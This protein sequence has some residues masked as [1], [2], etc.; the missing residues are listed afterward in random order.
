[1]RIVPRASVRV[2]VTIAI[3]ITVVLSWI[4]GSGVANYF[5]YLSFRSLR[6]EMMK[7]PG[8]YARP[9]PEPRF[10][11]VEFLTGR[12]PIPRGRREPVPTRRPQLD[13]GPGRSPADVP[14]GS[15]PGPSPDLFELR[16]LLLRLGVALGLAVL[17]GAWLARKFTKPLTQLADGADAFQSGDFEYRIPARGGNE[18]AAVA[19]AMN[20]MA[21]RVSDQINRLES[22]AQRRRRFLAD[23][24]HELRSPVTTMETMAGALKDGLADEP[25]RREFAVAALVVTS[26]RLRRL[27]QDL[28]ELAKLDL[29]ELPL[30]M[31]HTDL[32]ELVSSAIRSHEVEASAAG[33]VLHSLSSTAAVGVSADPDRIVQVLNNVLENAISYAGSGAEISVEVED[34]D[35]AMVR[36][37]DTGKG[38]PAEDMPF[39]LDPFYR[40]DSART[41]GD[42]HSGLGLSIASR[43]I[44]AH[45]GTLTITSEEGSGTQVTIAIPKRQ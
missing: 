10:G 30:A 8:I 7:H 12:P 25:E 35:P 42:S 27:V 11:I 34:G 32:C 43:L 21:E 3:L 39:V 4:I 20:E 44:E 16:G 23:I 2:S 22:D 9:I 19:A 33:V 13:P 5:G 17:A 37:T 38:I 1:M 15:P 6:Q 18:F 40:A 28:L 26:R 45:G 31:T 36:V 41:P 24:A 29:T 14:H